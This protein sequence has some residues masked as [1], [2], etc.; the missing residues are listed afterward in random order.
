ML[1]TKFP[2][3]NFIFTKPEDMT[4]EQCMDL[5]VWRG[6]GADGVP[7]IISYWKLSYEDLQE[8]N[9]TG[10]VWLRIIGS[11]MPP[12]ALEVECPFTR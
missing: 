2:E 7:M 4:D 6:N 11:G 8:I 1:P 12:V 10:G 3:A 9:K 5:P